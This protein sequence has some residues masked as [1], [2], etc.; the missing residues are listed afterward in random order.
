MDNTS[1]YLDQGAPKASARAVKETSEHIVEE[2]QSRQTV[3]EIA[4]KAIANGILNGRFAPGQRLVEADL[5]KELGISR[6]PLREAFGRLVAEGLLQVEPFRGAIVARLSRK[7]LVDLFSV[8]ECLESWAAR[9]AAENIDKSPFR[10][11]VLE[12]EASL[13]NPSTTLPNVSD[14]LEDNRKFHSLILKLAG[15]SHLPKLLDQLQF[16]IFQ[17]AFFR[18][19][20]AN[21]Y[22]NSTAEHYEILQA[23]LAG[24]ADAAST[25]VAAHVRHTS[26]LLYSLPDHFFNSD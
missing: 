21:I 26:K 13:R 4:A 18:M 23:I 2:R 3:V 15:N 17:S 25:R 10:N 19:Y 12:L 9:L 5:T 8:R 14:Y 16:P 7:E 1:N 20:D 24:D 22:Q 11:Y 6:N